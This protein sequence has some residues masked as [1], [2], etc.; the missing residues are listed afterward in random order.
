[1]NPRRSSEISSFKNKNCFPNLLYRKGRLRREEEFT[2]EDLLNEMVCLCVCVQVSFDTSVGL[3]CELR[4][5]EFTREYL[6]NEMVCLS[7]CVRV[8]VCMCVCVCLS[9]SLCVCVSIY[10][11]IYRKKSLPVPPSLEKYPQKRC[12]VTN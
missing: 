8:R 11:Y 7:V 6:L 5:E 10:V 1:M 4:E 2:R 3:F 9:L 12:H